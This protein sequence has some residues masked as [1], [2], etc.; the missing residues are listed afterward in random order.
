MTIADHRS[1]VQFRNGRLC[2]C[3]DGG[4]PLVYFDGEGNTLCHRCG[5]RSLRDFIPKFRTVEFDVLY[6]GEVYCDACSKRIG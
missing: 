5:T 1:D 2:K 4:Y 6:E 3:T